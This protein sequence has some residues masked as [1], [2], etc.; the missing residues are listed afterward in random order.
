MFME[1]AAKQLGDDWHEDSLGISFD[2]HH[3]AREEQV[4]LGHIEK[5]LEKAII[6]AAELG[7]ATTQSESHT[8]FDK[9]Q[10]I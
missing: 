3:R 1:I 9:R 10:I 7:F 5:T 8:A 4:R 2:D 6:C